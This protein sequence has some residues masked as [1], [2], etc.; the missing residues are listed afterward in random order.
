M[1]QQ[2]AAV[3]RDVSENGLCILVRR[4]TWCWTKVRSTAAPRAGPLP[5][6]SLRHCGHG[7][8]VLPEE[9]CTS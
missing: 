2:W 1:V 3:R 6:R 9:S 5:Q 8:C 7:R 4:P